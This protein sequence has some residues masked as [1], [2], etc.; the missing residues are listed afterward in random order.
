[1]AKRRRVVDGLVVYR[2]C[3]GCHMTS[4]GSNTQNIAT[5]FAGS[6]RFFENWFRDQIPVQNYEGAEGGANAQDVE[7]ILWGRFDRVRQI[8]YWDVQIDSAPVS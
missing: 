8:A 3:C 7:D 5:M 1:V 4:A 6:F 2:T